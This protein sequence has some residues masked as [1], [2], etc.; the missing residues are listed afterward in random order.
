MSGRLRGALRE[1]V[2]RQID[3]ICAPVSTHREADAE[4][5]LASSCVRT[6]LSRRTSSSPRGPSTPLTSIAHI[7]R[8]RCGSL[9]GCVGD[10][11][12][13][14]RR[15]HIVRLPRVMLPVTVLA[16]GVGIETGPGARVSVHAAAF[17]SP[18]ALTGGP[19][20]HE[21]AC[22]PGGDA[23]GSAAVIPGPS[24]AGGAADAGSCAF[25]RASSSSTS[26]PAVRASS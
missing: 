21:V 16:A 1:I 7:S 23:G 4:C 17:S 14:M 25:I 5:S 24:T 15:L 6:V 22:C 10:F 2:A 26:W 9:F 13:R 8:I 11:W 20:V 12:R 19:R 18:P 3:L